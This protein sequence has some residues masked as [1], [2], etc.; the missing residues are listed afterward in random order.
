[1]NI[2]MAIKRVH[3]R[4]MKQIYVI[5]T[6]DMYERKPDVQFC[7]KPLKDREKYF[8]VVPISQVLIKNETLPLIILFLVRFE[9]SRSG[10]RFFFCISNGNVYHESSI[11]DSIRDICRYAP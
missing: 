11:L 4:Y 6:I 9:I 5:N 3:Q 2:T 10:V 7:V 8:K 1:M